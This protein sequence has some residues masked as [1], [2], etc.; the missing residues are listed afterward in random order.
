MKG[1]YLQ[2]KPLA[3]LLGAVLSGGL[4]MRS[5][6]EIARFIEKQFEWQTEASMES[7]GTHYGLM[8]AREL[9]DFIFG[10]KPKTGEEIHKTGS[11]T[12]EKKG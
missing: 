5:R 8:E 9:M 7:P 2:A 11:Y 10:E 6:D 4:M 1:T 3:E 12:S